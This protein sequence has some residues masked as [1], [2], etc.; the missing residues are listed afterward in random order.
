MID[1]H[2]GEFH[3]STFVEFFFWGVCTGVGDVVAR[4]NPLLVELRVQLIVS[5]LVA[6]LWFIL[7]LHLSEV[8][9]GFHLVALS[10]GE[11]K[12]PEQDFLP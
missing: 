10:F 6:W 12:L 9:I 4:R 3:E 2:S 8:M 11:T 5:T 1:E 7:L